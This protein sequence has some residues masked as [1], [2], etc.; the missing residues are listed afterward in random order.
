MTHPPHPEGP[1]DLF[2]ACNQSGHPPPLEDYIIGG[3]RP[4]RTDRLIDRLVPQV[5]RL[6]EEERE[7]LYLGSWEAP[8]EDTP[9]EG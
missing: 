7:K 8:R 3:G 9:P 2:K 1:G 4:T 5:P 6:T